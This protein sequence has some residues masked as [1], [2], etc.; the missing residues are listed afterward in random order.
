LVPEVVD[1]LDGQIVR[2]VDELVADVKVVKLIFS[3]APDK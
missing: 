1:V 2:V 3:D